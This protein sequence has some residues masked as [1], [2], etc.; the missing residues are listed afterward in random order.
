MINQMSQA[1]IM[2]NRSFQDFSQPQNGWY[3]PVETQSE[4]IK[5]ERKY[6]TTLAVS[7]LAAGFGTLA[8]MKGGFAK[9]LSKYLEKC[10]IKLENKTAEN[11][12]LQRFYRYALN[13]TNSF[14]EKFGSIN[15]F[16]SLKDV[17]FQKFMFGKNGERKFT[18]NIHTSITNFFNKLGRK[19]VN[20]SYA[21]TQN[22]FA[23]LSEHISSINE[24][25]LRE[26][27]NNPELKRALQE[28]SERLHNANATLEQGF[29]LNARANR[30]TEMN[31]SAEPL[32][33]YFW[34]A[35][36]SDIRN[37]KSKNMWQTFI[38]DEFLQPTK[39]KLAKD[40]GKLRRIISNNI[41]DNYHSSVKLTD[42]LQRFIDP[43]DS[44]SN[45]LLSKIR[46]GLNKYKSLSGSNEKIERA[47]LNDEIVNNLRELSR[48]FKGAE[49]DKDAIVAVD[50]HLSELENI[51][52]KDSKGELQKILSIYKKH[53]SNTEYLKL[54]S[55]IN[56]TVNSLDKAIDTETVQYFDKV[57][58]LK[59]GSAPT[60]ILSI[61]GTTG[62]VGWFLAKA[63]NKDERISASLKYGIPA[64][65]AIATTLFTAARLVSGGKS[66]ALGLLSGWLI[67][68]VGIKVD[69]LRKKYSVDISF[70]NKTLIKPQPD[71][72]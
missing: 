66:L 47:A 40:T 58:D 71:K 54:K 21:K 63:K 32:F 48:T 37:F 17:L 14:I 3:L 19:T 12:T 35:S 49:Y 9:G 30:L 26:N 59:L 55:Q 64:V 18:K 10:R 20:S 53:L 60:D 33:D 68:K 42:N 61:L 27:P 36:F 23:R 46:L 16:T 6:G 25:L 8:F 1:N 28:V 38:A 52:A 43:K 5:K 67:N 24:R 69:D 22:K 44:A 62:I 56:S 45:E 7:A 29:G 2:T 72:V 57:R 39:M 41:E 15:N 34:N 65:G 13:K 51:I 31:A 11:G 50:S 4:K 70:K